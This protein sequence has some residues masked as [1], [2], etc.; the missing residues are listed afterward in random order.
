MFHTADF[1]EQRQASLL[2]EAAVNFI[3]LL[4]DSLFAALN[5]YPINK[6]FVLNKSHADFADYEDLLS[7][8]NI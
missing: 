5:I 2:R 6:N 7:V 1:R 3:N 4:A 8:F